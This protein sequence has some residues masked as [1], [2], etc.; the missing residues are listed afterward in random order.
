MPQKGVNKG[1]LPVTVA[2]IF[3]AILVL[4]GGMLLVKYQMAPG[5]QKPGPERLPESQTHQGQSLSEMLVFLHPKCPCS[6]ATV[7]ELDRLMADTT[8][9]LKVK[10]YFVGPQNAADDWTQSPLVVRA[11]SIPN[12]EVAYDAGGAHAK[13]FGA[14]TSG[15]AFVFDP[16]GKKV[17]QGGLTA[18]R[19][20]EGAN[21]GCASIVE[22]VKTGKLPPSQPPVFG[23]A[24]GELGGALGAAK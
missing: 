23:C 12:I 7:E 16:K 15:Q 24:F 1:W 4:V 22:Y 9:K 13:A 21:E 5:E 8:G 3:W 11:R 6:R 14:L 2:V 19:G 18:S 17:Y 20:H 10:A